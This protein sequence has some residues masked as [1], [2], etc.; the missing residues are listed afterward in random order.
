M[1][2]E[3]KE[4]KRII[5]KRNELGNNPYF[6]VKIGVGGAI[7]MSVL[8]Y[9]INSD[10]GFLPASIA[11]AKQAF[12]TFFVAGINLKLA[13][14]LAIKFKSPGLSLFLAVLIPSIVTIG[15]TYAVHSLKGTP[16]P[17]AS[18]IPTIILGPPSIFIFV[19]QKRKQLNRIRKENA[20]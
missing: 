3:Q 2:A 10:Y 14:N 8:V 1:V 4:K 20:I 17:F 6:N 5:K 9:F 11:A 19:Y 13:E 16:E 7:F 18:T 15:L 12:Y